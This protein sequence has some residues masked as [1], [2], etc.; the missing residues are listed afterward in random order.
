MQQI[1]VWTTWLLVILTVLPNHV[2]ASSDVNVTMFEGISKE[3]LY[4]LPM[5]QC[6]SAEIHPERPIQSCI[7]ENHPRGVFMV[8]YNET[9]CYLCYTNSAYSKINL[10]HI[11][12]VNWFARQGRKSRL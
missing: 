9:S 11:K 2:K 8:G 3:D 1:L 5:V 4:A 12:G 7:S 6:K 10:T